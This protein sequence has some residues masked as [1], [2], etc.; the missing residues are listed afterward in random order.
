VPPSRLAH[1]LV[2][3]VAGLVFLAGLLISGALGAVLLFAVAAFLVVLS[4]AAWSSIP[5]R[6]RRTRAL[7]VALVVM[8]AVIKLVRA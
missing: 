7:I 6:G 1:L 2:A 8:V 5:P 3:I 4:F